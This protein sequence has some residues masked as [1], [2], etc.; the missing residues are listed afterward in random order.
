MKTPGE[1][2]STVLRRVGRFG[3]V[4]A[5]GIVVQVAVLEMLVRCG[6]QYLLATGIAIELAV[7]HNFVW[8]QKFTWGDRGSTGAKAVGVRLTR[9][10][11]SNGCISIV[12]SLLLMRWLVGELE[13]GVIVANLVTIAACGVAN[14]VASEHWVFVSQA[15]LAAER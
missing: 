13:M 1:T 12:G 10:H 14:F 4:G 11:V 3:F 15:N 5:L 2:G 8:H 9:F 6:C 7:L